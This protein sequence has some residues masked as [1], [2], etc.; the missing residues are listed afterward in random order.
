MR[1][2]EL[3]PHPFARD[4]LEALIAAI[5]INDAIDSGARLPASIG[6]DYPAER[7]T[8]GFRLSRQLWREGFD[9]RAL[10]AMAACLRR[11]GVLDRP[12]QRHFKQIRARFKHLRFAFYLYDARHRS[13]P[14]LSLV[15]LVLGELQDSFR[16]REPADIRRHA[17]RLR[18]LLTGPAR[19]LLIHETNRFHPSDA[20]SFRC[21]TESEIASLPPLLAASTTDAHAFHAARK[22]V[23]RRVSFHDDMRTLYPEP[24]HREMARALATINGLMGKLHDEL[25]AR[26]AAGTFRYARD[27]FALPDDIRVRLEQLVALYIG[28]SS[29]VPPAA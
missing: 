28:T 13:P 3:D 9:W 11:G 7:F 24:E 20:P 10:D 18:L 15:T 2:A 25:V 26:D 21:F 1:G 6:L 27:R 12:E 14:V 23:S 8:Q 16:V 19:A 5:D 17:A 22:V 29:S 4:R